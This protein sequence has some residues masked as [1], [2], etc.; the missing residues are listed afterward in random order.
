MI[1]RALTFITLLM[2]TAALV[3]SLL[4]YQRAGGDIRAQIGKLQQIVQ[5]SRQET[6][7]G[8]DRIEK[9]VRGYQE[10]QVGAQSLRER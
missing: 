1:S 8:L 5:S 6:A 3:I 9:F 10:S 7:N 2:S 4:A